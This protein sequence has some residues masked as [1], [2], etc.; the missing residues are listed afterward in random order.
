MNTALHG[1]SKGSVQGFLV[2]TAHTQTFQTIKI[3][4][5]I[6]LSPDILFL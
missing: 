2:I 4:V 5:I 6:Q 3:S 1:L